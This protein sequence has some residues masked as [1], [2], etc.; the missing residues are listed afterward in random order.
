MQPQ[1][2]QSTWQLYRS[3]FLFTEPRFS[4]TGKQ[5]RQRPCSDTIIDPLLPERLAH[6]LTDLLT[7]AVSDAVLGAFFNF[8]G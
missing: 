8:P 5:P 4:L 1:S 6:P 2:M 3:A 7:D